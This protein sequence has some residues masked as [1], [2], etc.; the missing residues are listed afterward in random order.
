[1]A[2]LRAR[3]SVVALAVFGWWPWLRRSHSDASARS[4]TSTTAT[5]TAVAPPLG[6]GFRATPEWQPLQDWGR[7]ASHQRIG[8][9]GRAS[10]FG[11]YF[12]YGNDLSNHV[13]YIGQQ[14]SH[15]TFRPIDR[16]SLWR[17]TINEGALRLHRHDAE[18]GP[19]RGHGPSREPLDGQ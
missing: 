19:G 2:G 11:Q 13:Q 3:V 6:G 10:A 16:C 15:G 14:L 8:V 9:V 1:V 17:R 18:A 4:S 12:F 7:E 5:I